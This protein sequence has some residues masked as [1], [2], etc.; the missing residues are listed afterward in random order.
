LIEA[1]AEGNDRSQTA[2]DVFA[3][4]AKKYIGAYY[5]ALDG[6]DAI[7]FTGGIGERAPVVRAKICEKLTSLG[8][9]IDK[10]KNNRAVGEEGEITTKGSTTKVWVVPTNEELLLARDTLRCMLGLPHP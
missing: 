4:R 8:I 7:I 5:A 3:Y 9:R 2:I 6:A 1:A 10:R